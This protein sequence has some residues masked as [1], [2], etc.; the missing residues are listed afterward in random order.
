MFARICLH[1]IFHPLKYHD[2]KIQTSTLFLTHVNVDV[3]FSVVVAVVVNF[4][5]SA[6]ESTFT[7]CDSQKFSFYFIICL[8]SKWTEFLFASS[9]FIMKTL[10]CSTSITFHIFTPFQHRYTK[11]FSINTFIGKW[12]F[13]PDINH[14]IFALLLP[15]CTCFKC[16]L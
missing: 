13:G 1:S 10:C 9:N 4:F 12:M 14:H 8:L 2:G 11:I 6:R 3:V 15:L 16:K 7:L 5:Y